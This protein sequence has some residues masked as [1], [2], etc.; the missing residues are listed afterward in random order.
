MV[1]F[2]NTK[3][4]DDWRNAWCSS[5]EKIPLNNLTT[6]NSFIVQDVTNQIEAGLENESYLII[7]F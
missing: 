2:Y 7:L 3:T 6:Q 4:F 5:H 1:N